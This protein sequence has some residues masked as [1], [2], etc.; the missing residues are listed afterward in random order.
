M[1]LFIGT[2]NSGKLAHYRQFLSGSGIEIITPNDLNIAGQPEETA[3]TVE[4]NA[5]LKAKF[6]F[7]KSRL[8]TLC[9]DAG[10]EIPA[11]GNWPGTHAHRINGQEAGDR[12]IIDAIT[13]RM[14]NLTGEDR[15]ARMRVVLAL[16]TPDGKI[17]TASG[18]ISGLVPAQHYDKLMPRF[19]YRSLLFLPELNKWFYDLTE[20]EENKL[21]YRRAALEKIKSYLF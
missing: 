5:I 12:E 2:T 18:E 4:G 11:L 20:A 13:A 3:D 21:G 16:A 6:Y 1:K 10:F 7:Q 17:R 19:P 15:R 14:K 9:D 8:P